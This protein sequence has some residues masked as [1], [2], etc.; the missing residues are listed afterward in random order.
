VEVLR[1]YFPA[2]EFAALE[3]FS[4]AFNQGQRTGGDPGLLEAFLEAMPALR[5]GFRSFADGLWRNGDLAAG[6][7][8]YLNSRS[9][10]GGSS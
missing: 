5:Q 4:A 7:L 3:A 2:G 10:S 6:L 1:P 8:A 9:E